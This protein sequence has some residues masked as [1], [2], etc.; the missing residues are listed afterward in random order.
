MSALD[1][2]ENRLQT[3]TGQATEKYGQGTGNK[4]QQ[5]QVARARSAEIASKPARR[6]RISSSSGY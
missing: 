1:K 5:A 2:V 6:S 4:G 3:L